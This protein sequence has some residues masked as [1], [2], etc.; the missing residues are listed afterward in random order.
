MDVAGK[1]AAATTTFDAWFMEQLE[2]TQEDWTSIAMRID[3]DGGKVDYSFLADLPGMREW[4]GDRVIHGLQE[5]HYSLVNKIWEL[6]IGI[7]RQDIERER[8]G[9]YKLKIQMIPDNMKRDRDEQLFDLVV[10]STAVTCWDGRPFFDATHPLADGTTYSNVNAA[11]HQLNGTSF[12]A[13]RAVLRRMKQWNGRKL[14]V[15]KKLLLMVGPELE[16]MGTMLLKNDLITTGGTNQRKGTADLL[17]RP[18][19][20]SVQWCLAETGF[21]M[22]PWIMQIERDIE[23]DRQE[24]PNQAWAAF[25]RNQYLYGGLCQHNV[26]VGAPQLAYYSS[27]IGVAP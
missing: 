14:N 26:G 6:T 1:V 21:L 23:F 22:K 27:G 25:M 15:G 24:D 11:N 3:N 17:V 18:E 4:V 16:S 5:F 20:N 7:T 12:D 2:A 10:G 8:L 13:A 19:F 9:Q